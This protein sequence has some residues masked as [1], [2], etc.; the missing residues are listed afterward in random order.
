MNLRKKSN[1]SFDGEYFALSSEEGLLKIWETSTNTLKQEYVLKSSVD[2]RCSCLIW[3]PSKQEITFPDLD[4][5]SN[6]LKFPETAQYLILGSEK[7]EI[8]LLDLNTGKFYS[9]FVNSHLNAVNDLCWDLNTR[10]LFSCSA[11]KCI[12]MWDMVSG[13]LNNKW[14]ADEE[15]LHSI[16]MID[17]DN[18]L[19]ASTSVT[20]WNVKEQTIIKKFSDYSSEILALLPVISTDE[21]SNSYCLT[22]TDDDSRI[23]AWHL[24]VKNSKTAVASFCIQGDLEC[25]DVTRNFSKN[26]PMFLSAVVKGGPLYLFKHV[27]NGRPKK[28]L[29]PLITLHIVS[30]ATT[31]SSKPTPI[32]IIGS[33]F[34][35]DSKSCVL[36]YGNNENP[37]FERVKIVDCPGIHQLL[38]SKPVV[39]KDS[40]SIAYEV[41]IYNKVGEYISANGEISSVN[42]KSNSSKRKKLKDH[43]TDAICNEMC[44]VITPNN[45]KLSPV[46]KTDS[47]TVS[48]KL[49]KTVKRLVSSRSSSISSVEDL[50]SSS[51]VVDD[52]LKCLE[53]QDETL[54]N[55]VLQCNDNELIRRSVNMIPRHKVK[56]LLEELHRRLIQQHWVFSR[57][58]LEEV[59][60]IHFEYIMQNDDLKGIINLIEDYFNQQRINEKVL[61]MVQLQRLLDILLQGNESDSS[62]SSTS[63]TDEEMET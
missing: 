63:D 55:V 14:E 17:S 50:P 23:S 7:G 60:S 24:N 42:S 39:N 48:K 46:Y 6:E 3:G 18:L 4:E 29:K 51:N 13:N 26:N 41:K 49:P 53:T 27:L 15:P 31:D 22:A 45:K 30:K 1:F 58:W 52:L 8:L 59:L 57:K 47:S 35:C 54:L 61:K 36:A 37:T 25:I 5:A 21:P 16:C 38:R 33:V 28:N 19:A 11:D 2:F 40:P 34:S 20:W 12:G 32:P 10:T 9:H 44:E 43:S 62:S 56:F